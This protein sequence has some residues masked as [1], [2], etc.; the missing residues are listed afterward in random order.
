VRGCNVSVVLDARAKGKSTGSLTI[1]RGSVAGCRCRVTTTDF[2]KRCGVE[3][4]LIEV[5]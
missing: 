3:H 4:V 5:C 2:D 1:L